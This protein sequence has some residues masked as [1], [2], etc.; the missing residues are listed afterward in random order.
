LTP[1]A[2]RNVENLRWAIR[3][4]IDETF[5][6]F[7]ALVRERTASARDATQGAVDAA[8]T[9]RAARAEGIASE[10]T[11]LHQAHEDLVQVRSA[12]ARVVA[13]VET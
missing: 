11:G 10:L 9:R 6:R 7:G 13:D 4:G 8:S 3:L 5:R 1:L 2:Q 12:I